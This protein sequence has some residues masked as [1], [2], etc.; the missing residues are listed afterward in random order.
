MTEP[1][2]YELEAWRNVQRFR[3]RRA[4]SFGDEEEF[5]HVVLVSGGLV[6]PIEAFVS[7]IFRLATHSA[8]ARGSAMAATPSFR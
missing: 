1:S 2:A 3:G 5:P 6:R 4:C 7:V 8:K